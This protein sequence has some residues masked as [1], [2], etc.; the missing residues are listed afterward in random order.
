MKDKEF[1]TWI[2]D[3]LAFVHKEN[4]NYDYMHKLRAIIKATP[5]EQYTPNVASFIE[6]IKDIK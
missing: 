5:Q 2:H 3:R 6:S 4:I 1:L